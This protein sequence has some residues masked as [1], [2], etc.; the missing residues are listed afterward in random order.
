MKKTL[1]NKKAQVGETL[2]WMVAT[3][4]ILV[5]LVIFVY[6]SIGLAES[7]NIASGAST[8]SSE[9]NWMSL[10]TSLA[11]SLNNKNQKDIE[12]WINAKE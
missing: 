12:V 8:G 10:K 9:E 3:I 1:S 7:K 11:L 6:A 4:I 2:T 5:V